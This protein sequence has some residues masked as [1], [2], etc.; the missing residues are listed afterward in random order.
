MEIFDK[1]RHSLAVS[2]L[3]HI[4]IIPSPS[5]AKLLAT[6]WSMASLPCH[7]ESCSLIDFLITPA[8]IYACELHLLGISRTG[9]SCCKSV[10]AHFWPDLGSSLGE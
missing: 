3:Y 6:L 5:L 2:C 9:C 1:W 8:V 10:R 4:V 7:V